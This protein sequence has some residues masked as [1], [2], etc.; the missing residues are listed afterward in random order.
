MLVEINRIE[1]DKQ[2]PMILSLDGRLPVWGYT[3]HSANCWCRVDDEVEEDENDEKKWDDKFLSPSFKINK[4]A[5]DY[6]LYVVINMSTQHAMS[7]KC[8]VHN[9]DKFQAEKPFCHSAVP[10]SQSSS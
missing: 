9:W 10:T 4:G 2:T 6:A 3:T 7:H 1:Y 8:M 5:A